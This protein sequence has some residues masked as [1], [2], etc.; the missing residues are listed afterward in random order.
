M[1]HYC[2]LLDLETLSSMKTGS[3]LDE[4]S[5]KNYDFMGFSI[6]FYLNIL[7]S[8]R[9]LHE[10]FSQFHEKKKISTVVSHHN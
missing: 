4:I 2:R 9:K 10:N 5:S 3:E 6:Y 7:F 8:I 1:D